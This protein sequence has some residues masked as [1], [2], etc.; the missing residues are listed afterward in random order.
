MLAV[1]NLVHQSIVYK[2]YEY[3]YGKDYCS[4]SYYRLGW[5]AEKHG[6]IVRLRAISVTREASPAT[7]IRWSD[8]PFS[9]FV[10]PRFFCARG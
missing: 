3:N 1:L 7:K 10:L 2:V 4:I 9:S 8:I 5:V 6:K